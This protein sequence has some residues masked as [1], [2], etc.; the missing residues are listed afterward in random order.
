MASNRTLLIDL[1]DRLLACGEAVPARAESF[2]RERAAL[3]AE[4]Q[5]ALSWRWVLGLGQS[6]PRLRPRVDALV[7][8]SLAL[9]E[10]FA[11][12]DQ[13]EQQISKATQALERIAAPAL[14]DPAAIPA[15]LQHLGLEAR[16]LGRQVKTDDDLMVD[17]RRCDTA[18]TASIR[19][20]EALELWLSAEAVLNTIRAST[21]TAALEAA[22][23]ELG[24][25]LCRTGPTPQWAA[26]FKALVDPL[27][28]LA[29]RAQPREITETEKI[30][31]ALPRWARALGEDGDDCAALAERFKARRKDWPGE[32]DRTFEELFEQARVLEQ[33]LMDRAAAV[34]CDGIAD[35]ETRCVLFAQLV[36]PDPGLDEL[37]RDLRADTPDNPR[38]HEDWC[39]QLRDANAA[40]GNRVKRSEN[41]LLATLSSVLTQC[42]QRLAA[43]TAIPRLDEKDVQLARMRD[44]LDTLTRAGEEGEALALLKALEQVRALRADLEGLEV[45]IRQDHAGL[46]EARLAL[47]GRARWLVERTQGLAITLPDL[48]GLLDQL[49]S[50]NG[51]R[52]DAKTPSGTTPS[53]L[54]LDQPP[55]DSPA[56][57]KGPDSLGALASWRETPAA[58]E[59]SLEEIRLQ[60]AA[61]Q[62]GLAAAEAQFA[63]VCGESIAA[64][65]RR[66]AQ[67]SALLTPQSIRAGGLAL[68][69]LRPAAAGDLSGIADQL[70][71]VRARLAGVD[72]LLVTQE[73]ALTGRAA[74]LQEVLAAI[75][76]ERLGHNDRG[77]RE[78]LLRQ[79][80][81]WRP[82][83][84]ADALERIAVLR[85]WIENAEHVQRRIESAARRLRELREALRERL[86]RFNGLF[87]QGYCPDLYVRVEGLVHPPDET[88]WQRGAE[89][90]QL[91]EAERLLR[92]LECQ[93]QRLAAREIGETLRVLEQHARR[94]KD[95][96]SSALVSEV[97]ALPL[98]QQPPAR[99]RRRLADQVIAFGD[100]RLGGGS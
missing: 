31:K 80:Q 89:A 99:L 39:E 78:S 40:F 57:D 26:E 33:G 52:Q 66:L 17:E 91:A 2:A 88:H 5:T 49:Q 36:G 97:R 3:L 48:A 47:Q 95:P 67:V 60:L 29:H 61:Q 16:R 27:D 44:Q 24:E 13:I 70:G 63:Q 11:G 10:L 71:L 1:R 35:L 73:Q 100:Q 79:F 90:A 50:P 7:A 69:P 19:L 54:S 20:T 43:L 81:Q 42:R 51:S 25:R 92:L 87:L 12:I 86:R 72:A 30:I 28:Q 9:H 64:G 83:D 74:Q 18:R 68:A 21:R 4:V 77:D 76:P 46:D 14:H 23:P 41:A 22:L 84:L 59:P 34:R 45:A 93:A 94:T 62:R 96:E 53:S 98:E 6:G 8:R 85:E 58:R 65:N 37:V 38:D 15:L 32:D 75:P 55:D 56:A 82:D